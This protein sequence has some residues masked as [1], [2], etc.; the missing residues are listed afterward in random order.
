LLFL[1]PITSTQGDSDL[2]FRMAYF[3][4]GAT[5]EL[6]AFQQSHQ[7]ASVAGV[8]SAQW[9]TGIVI[10]HGYLVSVGPSS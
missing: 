8:I 6:P 1:R 5:E 2:A 10:G 4:V 7:V 9:T 3:S